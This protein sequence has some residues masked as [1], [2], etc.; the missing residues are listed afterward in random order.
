MV[1]EAK[2]LVA[3]KAVWLALTWAIFPMFQV[4]TGLAPSVPRIVAVGAVSPE[5]KSSVASERPE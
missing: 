5:A 4:V 2:L 3:P 1:P